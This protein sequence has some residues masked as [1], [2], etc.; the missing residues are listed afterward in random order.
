MN[1]SLPKML[2]HP[3]KAELRG[4][5][6]AQPQIPGW[7][8]RRAP[9][10]G[11]S[12]RGRPGRGQP[13]LVPRC[14]TA[15]STPRPGKEQRKEA[16]SWGRQPR[17]ST[18]SLRTWQGRGEEPANGSCQG[19]SA[20]ELCK[21]QGGRRLSRQGPRGSTRLGLGHVAGGAGGD[22]GQRRGATSW[23]HLWPWVHLWLG[24]CW[25][26]SP[27]SRGGSCSCRE[28]GRLGGTNS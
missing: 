16:R 20:G 12:Q 3:Y 21:E 22:A 28:P 5:G 19:C 9:R 14:G 17:H 6:A 4:P 13:L 10:V 25:G 24:P 7:R 2:R 27:C 8:G 11:G 15:C 18:S 26:S 23:L 1:I